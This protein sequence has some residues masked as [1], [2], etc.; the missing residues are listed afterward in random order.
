MDMVTRATGF[1]G[2]RLLERLQREGGEVRVVLRRG[3][4]PDAV[5]VKA[6]L[7][8]PTGLAAACAGI[9]RVF[10]CA[11]HA[12]A[13]ASLSDEDEDEH[14]RVNFVGTCNLVEAAARAGVKRFAG[15]RLCRN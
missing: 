6:D 15:T 8:D 1:I 3:S 2:Q 4:L 10:H 12:H 11:G 13:F 7:G 14:W 9:E 5:V